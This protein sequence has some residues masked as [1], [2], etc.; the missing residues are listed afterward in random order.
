MEAGC[1]YFGQQAQRGFCAEGR[2]ELSVNMPTVQAPELTAGHWIGFP[3][4]QRA[5]S[6]AN[7]NGVLAGTPAPTS[8]AVPS[9]RGEVGNV[10]HRHPRPRSPRT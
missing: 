3:Q 6:A 5:G 8:P 7:V 9:T 4:R 1:G 10:R 2:T